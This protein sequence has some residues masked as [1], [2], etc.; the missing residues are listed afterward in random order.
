MTISKKYKLVLLDRDGTIIVNKHYLS[1]PDKI[2]FLPGALEGLKLLSEAGIRLV[3]VSNQSGVGRGY[4][5]E[6][7]VNRVNERL[8]NLLKN[9]EIDILNVLYCPHSPENNCECRK[10]KPGMILRALNDSDISK[11]NAIIIG[12]SRADIEAGKK[13]GI[14]SILVRTGYG[15][16]VEK[17]L[18][19]E[20]LFVADNLLEAADIILNRK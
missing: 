13:A 7:E 19:S 11:D 14:D 9:E 16:E 18:G 10:P 17:E 8:V 1:D 20:R 4:F 12:D 6:K 2:E 5:T 15:K 3:I